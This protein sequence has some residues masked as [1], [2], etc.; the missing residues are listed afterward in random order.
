M[1]S[2]V[3][4]TADDIAQLL[5]AAPPR[6]VPAHVRR[7]AVAGRSIKG[8]MFVGGLFTVIGLF[9][10]VFFFPWDWGKE[11]RLAADSTETTMG[12]VTFISDTDVSINGRRVQEFWFEYAPAPGMRMQG[13]CYALEGTWEK[14][15]TAEVQ[16][17]AGEPQQACLTGGRLTKTG[18]WGAWVILF[19]LIGIWTIKMARNEQ[20]R[21]LRLLIRGR[22]SQAR[23]N[24]VDETTAK[25]NYQTV[26][27]IVLTSPALGEGQPV[28]LKRI[29]MKEVNL[30]LRHARTEQPVYVL[31]DSRYPGEVLF[32]E[33]WIGGN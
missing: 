19:P 1:N 26:Y 29:N 14:W 32:P 21:V 20:Q 17:L 8:K 15:D 28:T 27:R 33:A 24:S 25:E 9:L 4:V 3:K 22:V 12:T 13:K 10:S 23:I 18:I 16:Y 5:A 11:L 30:A 31:Y 7:A 6:K 2:L